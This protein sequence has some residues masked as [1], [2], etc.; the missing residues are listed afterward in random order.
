SVVAEF[1]GGVRTVFAFNGEG[2]ERRRFREASEEVRDT[3]I[4][5]TIKVATVRPL[6]EAVASV[7][8]I[9]LVVVSVQVLV[10][11]GALSVAA[12]LA[13]LFALFRIFP[14]VHELNNQRGTMAAGTGSWEHVAAL[15][16]PEGKPALA[17]GVLEPGPLRESI[18]FEGVTFAYG[19]DDPVLYDIDLEIRRGETVAFVGA[20]G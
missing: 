3:A 20:S 8:L 1:M 7:M 10:I 19:H 17:D 6:G 14:I 13:F 16:S 4:R 9:V 15:L 12:F 11:N 5:M 18:R 2:Y